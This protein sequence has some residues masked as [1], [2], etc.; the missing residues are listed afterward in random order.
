MSGLT[1]LD[2]CIRIP[3]CPV[4]CA[5]CDRSV[6]ALG[7]EPTALLERYAAA[8]RRE[9]EASAE[10]FRD[11]ELR[12]IR[13]GGG[14]AGH[15]FDESLG[16]LLS[17][18]H[19]LYHVAEDAQITMKCHPGM[20]SAETLNACRRGGVNR[21]SIEY[22]TAHV[23]ENEPLGRFL[24]PDAM[25]VTAIVLKGSGLRLS[26]DVL[27]GL[28]GQTPA[29][30]TETLRKCVAY[31]AEHLR[32]LPLRKVPGTL[33]AD[34]WIPA[35]A[36]S[37]SPR[38]HLPTAEERGALLIA[39]ETWLRQADFARYLD[40]CYARPGHESAYLIN[41]SGNAALLGFGAGAETV[42]DGMRSTTV[43]SVERYC[44]CSPDPVLLTDRI[45]PL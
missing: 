7:Q 2:L 30:L 6:Q 14:I 35:H 15:L 1:P 16:E 12:N 28:P 33:F 41:R 44:R 27:Y 36:K 34:S 29:S 39:A 32:L 24:T 19:R 45:R 3:F 11:C 17:D 40:G 31:G 13:I 9:A 42:L 18:I 23:F 8:L 25:D 26:M 5:F 10:D 20:I 38:Y 37:T 43:A 21:L 22:P 4:R